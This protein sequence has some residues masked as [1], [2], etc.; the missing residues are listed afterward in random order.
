MRKATGA[1]WLV[2]VLLLTAGCQRLNFTSTYKLGPKNVHDL[3]FDPPAY[4]QRVTVT[5]E[6]TGG[7]VSA[8]LMREEDSGAAEA[9][10]RKNIE[11]DGSKLLGFK[12]SRGPAEAYTFEATVPAKTGYALLLKNGPQAADVKVT[13]V[14]R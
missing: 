14:G 3:H 5:I 2:A 6:P 4:N 7:G 9:Q 11:P 8:Y 13:V 10:L 12:I 1:I